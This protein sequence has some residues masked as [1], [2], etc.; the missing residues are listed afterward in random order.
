MKF[1]YLKIKNEKSFQ[2]EMKIFSFFSEVFSFRLTKQSSK[3]VVDPT[4]MKKNW[5]Q[6]KNSKFSAADR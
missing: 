1:E 6:R 5:L 4:F 2:S 3:V